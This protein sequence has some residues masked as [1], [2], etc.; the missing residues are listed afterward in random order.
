MHIHGNSMAINQ[1]N[2]YSAAQIDRAAA[3]QKAI[4][5]RKK[6]LKTTSEI[7]ASPEETFMLG[8]WLDCS[9]QSEDEYHANT[10]G[11]GIRTLAEKR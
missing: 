3:A 2:P 5:V 11:G 10:P 7:E 8:H 4:D 6:L 9:P 1:A